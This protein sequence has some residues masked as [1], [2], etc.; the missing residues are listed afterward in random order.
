[1]R[2]PLDPDMFDPVCP[3][4]VVPFRFGDKWAAMVI[5]CLEDGPRR[6]SELRVPLRRASA[7]ALTQSLRRLERDGMV[8]RTVHAPQ[9]V[10]YALTPLGRSLLGQIDEFCAW[11]EEHWDE[12]LDARE[13]SLSPPGP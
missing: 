13:A 4:A 1:M 9:N 12:L 7:K 3:S 8:V 6:F 5:R 11:A 10:E 2:P